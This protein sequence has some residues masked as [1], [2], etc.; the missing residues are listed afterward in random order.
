MEIE[1]LYFFKRICMYQNW[2]ASS[3]SNQIQGG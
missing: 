3:E 2:T 1:K